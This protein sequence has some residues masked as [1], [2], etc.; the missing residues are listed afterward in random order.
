M[1]RV[2]M[3][4]L[5]VLVL[6]LLLTACAAPPPLTTAPPA[7][8]A[9]Q[10]AATA[11]PAQGLLATLK[12]QGKMVVGTSA[13]YP[14]YESVDENGNFV[15][16][17][18]DLIREI[19]KRMGL[20]V[21]IKDMAFDS[22]IAAL[23]QGKIDVVIAA[24]QATPERDEK[25]DFTIPYHETKDALLVKG[26]SDIV[27]N[28]PQD[29][30]GHSV[31]VQTGTIQEKWVRE[32]LVK[33][34]LMPED[35]VFVYE[36]VDNAA[37]DVANGRVDIL[38]IVADPA[39]KLAEQMNLKVA[40]ITTETVAGAQAIAVPEGASDLKAELDRI[41]TEI[42]EDGTLQSLQDKWGIP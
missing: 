12:E 9:E 8:A 34:G 30:A 26:D 32:H 16:L 25:V 38:F 27:L 19:G 11:V 35:Q 10:P 33:P 28:S 2:Q 13:D 14:P 1:K 40:L 39:I 15:G 29:I 4:F 17:D 42:R 24:M 23:Q 41:I 7:P 22:L 21:E 36:R 20:E 6:A 3:A 31:A 5:I 18:M 37:L